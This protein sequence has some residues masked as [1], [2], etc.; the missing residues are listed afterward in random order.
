VLKDNASLNL[1]TDDEGK[2]LT[3]SSG[4]TLPVDRSYRNFSGINL[5]I[6]AKGKR[7]AYC[8]ANVIIHILSMCQDSKL[9]KN[10]V[11]IDIEIENK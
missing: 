5:Q 3:N 1:I 6:K 10:I 4:N 11:V 2:L 9:S 8:C 7:Q